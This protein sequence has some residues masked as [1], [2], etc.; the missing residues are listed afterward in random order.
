MILS[1][2]AIRIIDMKSIVL[3]ILLLM[4]FSFSQNVYWQPCGGPGGEPVSCIAI[5]SSGIIYASGSNVL[6]RSSDGGSSWTKIADEPYFQTMFIYNDKMM[7]A[8]GFNGL[9]KSSDKGISWAQTSLDRGDV[10]SLAMDSTHHIYVATAD[11]GIFLSTDTGSTWSQL[12][13]G[14]DANEFSSIKVHPNGSIFAGSLNMCAGVYRSTDHG[15]AWSKID[16]G[17]PTDVTS[18]LYL[19]D[20][21]FAPDGSI[22]IATTYNGIFRSTNNGDNWVRVSGY[23]GSY[24]IAT[25]PGCPIYASCSSNQPFAGGI[26]RSYDNGQTWKLT[27]WNNTRASQILVRNGVVY[28]SYTQGVGFSSDSGSTWIARKVGGRF[29]SVNAMDFDSMGILYAG[30]DDYFLDDAGI[31]RSSDEGKTW[32]RRCVVPTSSYLNGFKIIKSDVMF[33]GTSTFS[34]TMNGGLFT[35][36]DHGISWRSI[37]TD[38]VYALGKENDSTIYTC[39]QQG[40]FRYNDETKTAQKLGDFGWIYSFTSKPGG[41]LFAGGTSTYGVVY[42]STDYGMTWSQSTKG[43]L[44]VTITSLAITPS[45][46]L[47]AGSAGNGIYRST[48]NGISW[49][50]TPIQTGKFSALLANSDGEI[51]AGNDDGKILKSNDDGVSWNDVSAGLPSSR[52]R[53]LI[54]D[55]EGFVIAGT[56]EYGVF[57]TAQPLTRVSR[58]VQIPEDFSLSRNYPNPFNPSTTIRFSVPTRSRLRLT[59]YNILGQQVAELANEVM[60]AGNFERIWNAKVGSGLYFYRLEAA[61]VND[62]NKRF[63]DVKKMILIK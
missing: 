28:A 49:I 34:G 20:I 5:D 40:L 18:A 61:S 63:V 26:I 39:G 62:P 13:I 47:L 42:C 48:D 29:Q 33:Y 15:N 19:N 45:G 56:W 59:I 7:F 9:L 36:S 21:A 44:P 1:Q 54:E 25:S 24:S 58:S 37:L 4:E 22:L 6:S 46:S 38:E 11:Y 43:N 53:C 31:H 16:N 60:D 32:T 2:S 35:S 41:V 55:R 10:R 52:I 23:A 50:M 30:S 17:L 14:L 8:A 57:R 3:M 51:L 12:T 27:G